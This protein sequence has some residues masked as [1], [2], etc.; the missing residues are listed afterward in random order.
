MLPKVQPVRFTARKEVFLH[1]NWVFELKYDGF[2]AI[3]CIEDGTARLVSRNGF[4]YRRFESLCEELQKTFGKKEL[5][6]DGEIACLDADGR[7]QFNQL[8]FRRQEP[9]FCAFDILW[10]DG[11]DLRQLPLLTRKR[12]L[13]R[14]VPKNHH[15]L[16]YVDSCEDGNGLFQLVCELDFE[17]IV[18]KPK[19]S[20]YEDNRWVKVKNPDYSQAKNR[21]KLFERK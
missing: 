19:S 2:R 13:R 18:M 11:R 9:T 7:P 5:I 17:G 6:L 16:M 4:V 21:H 12:I 14:V 20:P 3:A 8:F 15:S 10:K 1:P